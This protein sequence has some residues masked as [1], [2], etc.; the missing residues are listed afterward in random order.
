[1]ADVPENTSERRRAPRIEIFAQAEVIGQEIY[2]MEVRNIS[3]T[4][5]FLEGKPADYPDIVPGVDLGLA[6][7]ANEEGDD[8]D[9]N[10]ACHARIVRVDPGEGEGEARPAG[11]GATIEPID[12]ENRSRMLRL[13][14]RLINSPE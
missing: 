12:D 9:A 2:I 14:S 10:I 8:P 3:A 7:F 13:L 4:G 1:M 5:V 11:F 6:I